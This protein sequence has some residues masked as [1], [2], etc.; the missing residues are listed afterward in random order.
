MEL[1]RLG[2]QIFVTTHDY[3]L[4]KEFDLSTRVGDHICYH[5]LYRREADNEIAYTLSE[6]FQKKGITCWSTHTP[7]VI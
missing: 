4:L 2:V 3:V 1:Q 7:V 5:S 6:N